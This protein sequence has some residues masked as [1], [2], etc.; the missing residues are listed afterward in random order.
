MKWRFDQRRWK[1]AV[2]AVTRSRLAGLLALAWLCSRA[3]GA[4]VP[5]AS[6][7]RKNVQPLLARY[8]YDCHG[9]G[10]NKGGI[11]FDE[12]KTEKAL[13]D[14][15]LW[16]KALKNTR[17]GLMPPAKKPQPSAEE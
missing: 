3:Q 15:D 4:E 14:H 9:D 13:L 16:L 10:M 6:H 2:A 11:A 8:C 17:S 7:F 5:A 12:L 1:R